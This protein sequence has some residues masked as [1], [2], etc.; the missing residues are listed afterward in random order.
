ME[1]FLK[2]FLSLFVAIDLIGAIPIF[3]GLTMDLSTKARNVL[4][5]KASLTALGIGLLFVIAG[6]SIFRFLGITENDFRIA[7]G[8]LL[9]IF[10]IRD[11]MSETGHEA[12]RSLENIGVVPLGIPIIMGPASLT[13]ILLSAREFGWAVS[14]VALVANLALVWLGFR[15]SRIF[16]KVVGKELS[17]ALAKI[18]SLLLAAIAIMLIRLGLRGFLGT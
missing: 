11:L 18:F 6:E 5:S 10:A 3:L 17:Q 1:N 15:F 2:A 9:F 4:I 12:P 8:I 13:T 7:G 16:L 14:M